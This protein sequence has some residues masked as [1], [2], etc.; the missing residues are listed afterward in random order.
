MFRA[1]LL[2]TGRVQGV[3]YRQSMKSEAAALGLLGWVRNL[4]NGAVE[5]E[6]FGEEDKIQTLLEWCK[7]GPDRAVVEKVEPVEFHQLA[8]EFILDVNAFIVR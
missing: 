3:F 6:I 7:Q 1:K 8:P 2:I 4:H 5:A